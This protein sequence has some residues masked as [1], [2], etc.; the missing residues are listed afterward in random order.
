MET[1]L[2]HMVR[3]REALLEMI[4]TRRPAGSKSERRWIEKWILPLGVEVDNFGNLHK[5]IGTEP[6]LWSSHTDT[7]HKQGG[8]QLVAMDRQGE[9]YLP[10]KETISNCLGADDTAGVWL[11]REMILS[12]KEGL[13]IFHRDEEAGGHGSSFI[14][15]ETPDVLLG[16]KWAIALDRKGYD[17]V[18]THQFDR[19][20]S[21]DFAASLAEALGGDFSPDAGGIFTD[22]AN[23]TELVPECTNLSVGYFHAH[24]RT[25]FLSMPFLEELLGKLLVLE[26]YQ[27]PVS[28]DPSVTREPNWGHIE[29]L[30]YSGGS[31]RRTMVELVEDNPA[32]VADLLD[33]WGITTDELRQLVYETSGK[34]SA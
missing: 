30:D 17:S 20:C 6:V 12:G 4:A 29:P 1:T 13:Y 15:K 3:G 27:L 31:R 18:I 25:E 33:G 32:V 8:T 23:Y 26:T 16:I 10:A 22:T 14:A 7:V 28:R 2:T 24:R 9:I 34:V 5:R 21:D 11:M 19:C